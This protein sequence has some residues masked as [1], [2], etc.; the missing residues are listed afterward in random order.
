MVLSQ[1]KIVLLLAISVVIAACGYRI[2]TDGMF[3]D[4]MMYA[5]IARNLAE[6]FG[7]FFNLHYS[8]TLSDRFFGH[9]PLMPFLLSM[10][11]RLFGDHVFVEKGYTTLTAILTAFFMLKTYWLFTKKQQGLTTYLPLLFWV[12]T[13]QILWA[14]SNNM[15]ENTMSVF[16]GIAIYL[17]AF[18]KVKNSHIP[19]I[20]AGFSLILAFYTKGFTGL[21]PLAFP[22]M[23]WLIIE[24]SKHKKF[25][26]DTFILWVVCF[27]G[28]AAV[29]YFWPGAQEMM[30]TYFNAQILGNVRGHFTWKHLDVF[31]GF[32]KENLISIIFISIITFLIRK[33]KEQDVQ[34]RSSFRIGLFFMILA[35]CGV[36]PISLSEKRAL[37]YALCAFPV[38]SIGLAL[39]TLPLFQKLE[40]EIENRMHTRKILS[41]IAVI[42]LVSSIVYTLFNI[43]EPHRD[44][45]VILDLKE[46]KQI[47]PSGTVFTIPQ[48]L[49]QDWSLHALVVRYG[50]YSLDYSS[51]PREY[52]LR[53]KDGE[54]INVE[55]FKKIDITSRNLEIYKRIK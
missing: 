7:S 23:Y 5:G 38:F 21:F 4:G 18:S 3:F 10:F 14:Y 35:L 45:A 41:L 20:P 9:P 15:I 51:T 47:V 54:K 49:Y 34:D 12:L 50:R 2:L 28:I 46:I 37:Y 53:K 17:L 40:K 55:G 16:T 31:F 26:I 52:A 11:Y 6:G 33:K 8:Q 36:L 48:S 13:P 27:M 22:F 30:T 1:K 44:K 29:F 32:I 25:I 24:P 39:M 42:F 43:S 19:I